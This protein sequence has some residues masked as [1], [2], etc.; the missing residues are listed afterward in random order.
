MSQ[1]DM[2][3]VIHLSTA[4]D[5]RG[6]EHQMLLLAQGLR[7]RGIDTHILARPGSPALGRAEG[8]GIRATG[9]RIRNELDIPAAWRVARILK[10]EAA[11]IL[12]AHDAHAVAIARWAGWLAGVP[13]IASRRVNFPIRSPRKYTLGIERVLCVSEAIRSTC[14]GAGVPEDRLRVV[15]DGVDLGVLQAGAG[16]PAKTRAE[17][18]DETRKRRLVVLNVASLTEEKDH[19]TLLESMNEVL[20]SVP[21]AFFLI[22][23][24]GPLEG[25]LR[26][27]SK[28]LALDE[29]VLCLAGFREDVPAL[30]HAA[31]L[32]VMSSYEEGYCTSVMD[33][34]ACGKAVV[35]TQVGGLPELVEEGGT[36]R[37][38]PP[39]DPRALAGA[40][41]EL[42]KDRKRREKMGRQA[43]IK[44]EASFSAGRMVE[45]TLAAYREVLGGSPA[46]GPDAPPAVP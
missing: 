6:G 22:A 19:A 11:A 46:A 44:A 21:Q 23:G 14:L 9:V 38:V 39:Q 18:V 3:T 45:E 1:P 12:H 43:R 37:L 36:G 16:D 33:A 25:A 4:R 34:M 13:R 10:R 15:A 8:A 31:D 40:L 30:L 17:F 20:A 29:D 32:F 2:G 27:R 28:V 41:V 42:L 5:W 24:S 35:A 26:H 7:S